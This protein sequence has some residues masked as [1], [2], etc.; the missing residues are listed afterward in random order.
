MNIVLSHMD[1]TAG[2][3]KGCFWAVMG[4]E[5]QM[6]SLERRTECEDLWALS[7]GN[8]PV[9]LWKGTGCLVE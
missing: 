7:I 5:A 1:I 6:K 4:T 3:D 2:L 8:S 9:L